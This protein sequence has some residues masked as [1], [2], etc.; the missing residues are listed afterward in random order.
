M[1][2]KTETILKWQ[3]VRSEQEYVQASEEAHA[4]IAL[5]NHLYGEESNQSAQAIYHYAM[6][7]SKIKSREADCEAE[8][9]KAEAIME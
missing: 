7:L 2:C 6:T 1:M 3:G 5:S 8:L 4:A 9:A